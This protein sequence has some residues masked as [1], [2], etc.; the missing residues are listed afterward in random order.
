M[1]ELWLKIMKIGCLALKARSVIK[2]LPTLALCNASQH[3]NILVLSRTPNV[4]SRAFKDQ[5]DF[6]GLLMA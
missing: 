4:I 2:G 3:I 1:A 5:S 6:L